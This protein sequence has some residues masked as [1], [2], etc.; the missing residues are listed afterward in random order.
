MLDY[1]HQTQNIKLV[2]T[3]GYSSVS[4]ALS[5]S[6]VDRASYREVKEQFQLE[7]GGRKAIFSVD[8]QIGNRTEISGFPNICSRIDDCFSEL[9]WQLG[10]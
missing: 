10:E 9:W 7:C 4:I 5:S 2:S 3:S 6:H 1:W 8:P